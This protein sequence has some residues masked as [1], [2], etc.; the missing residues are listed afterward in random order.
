M[1]SQARVRA[2]R[3]KKS[4]LAGKML[5][6]GA[7]AAVVA[8][9][10]PT[11][12]SAIGPIEQTI[13]IDDL[14]QY[15]TF[16]AGALAGLVNG[17]GV[18]LSYYHAGSPPTVTIPINVNQS[19]DLPPGGPTLA[20]LHVTINTFSLALQQIAQ[21]PANLS[22]TTNAVSTWTSCKFQNQTGTS[23]RFPAVIGVGGGAFNLATAYRAEIASV[24]GNTWEGYTPF[25]AG[26]SPANANLTSQLLVFAENPLRPNGGLLTRFAPIANAFGIDT[27]VPAAGV[28]QSADGTT[29]L[30]SATLDATWAYDPLSDFPVT[31]NP[32]SLINSLLAFLPT[33]LAG[34]I[35]LEGINTGAA[36][37]NIGG[38][39]GF[40]Y[41]YTKD[42]GFAVAVQP[43]SEGQSFYATALPN[44][45]PILEPLR[46]PSRLI[47]YVLGRFGSSFQLGTPLADALEP[48]A[49]I[50]VNIGYSD[51]VTPTD[52]EDDPATY[53][54]Y[55]PYDRT[56]LTSATPEAFLSTRPLTLAEALKVPG[57]VVRALIAGFTGKVPA[58]Q[59]TGV[60]AV[61][62]P[63]VA[64]V[65][66]TD[67][68]SVVAQVN[69]PQR[70]RS[71]SP[72]AAS[73]TPAQVRART[74]SKIVGDRSSASAASAS[75]RERSSGRQQRS[76][77]A[78]LR[79]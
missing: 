45:L 32:V 51:V 26:A 70:G 9:G 2:S 46:L 57:D 49:K 25:E 41:K 76:H 6:A 54:E 53:A 48:A 64:A 60:A 18:S 39:L 22:N 50:L 16:T 47:N 75:G 17:L 3:R 72:T 43:V 44:D 4:G 8:L 69:S 13:A 38:V 12:A 79:G 71:T 11:V 61:P 5:S 58:A 73:V 14:L 37:L 7:A 1:S 35:K 24:Q 78:D 31:L 52:I 77:P 15:P 42:I 21:N 56:F 34:G 27:M 74:V 29:K 40:L 30:N 20:I 68:E 33:N 66:T 67:L 55:Q 10:V 65:T 59:S 28:Y 62:A 63:P 36:G 19:V 23:C